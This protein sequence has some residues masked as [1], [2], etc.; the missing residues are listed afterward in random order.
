MHVL[1]VLVLYTMKDDQ[2][3]ISITSLV[4]HSE[5]L[6]IDAG[7]VKSSYVMTSN[8]VQIIPL[9]CQMLLKVNCNNVL[10]K[11]LQNFMGINATKWSW[12]NYYKNACVNKISKISLL[13]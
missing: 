6:Y 5:G 12:T 8:W 2:K 11:L 10:G 7:I 3:T 9:Q 1:P 13:Y 4:I